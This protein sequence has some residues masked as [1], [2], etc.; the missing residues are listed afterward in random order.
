MSDSS[1]AARLSS[2][3]CPSRKTPFWA[4][5]RLCAHT[6]APYK[7]ELLWKR[8]GRVAAGLGPGP[9]CSPRAAARGRG[10][11][12]RAPPPR[13]GSR[14]PGSRGVGKR[15][16]G[17]NVAQRVSPNACRSTLVAQRVSLKIVPR[18]GTWVSVTLLSVSLMSPQSRHLFVSGEEPTCGDK[19]RD[20]MVRRSPTS[21]MRAR[22]IGTCA[23]RHSQAW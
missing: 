3:Y 4:A 7:T 1:S 2:P 18:R 6:N 23:M 19:C 11:G 12:G 14:R 10:C 17:P 20:P 8:E 15:Q 22:R 5:T 16:H 13:G 21:G 9:W